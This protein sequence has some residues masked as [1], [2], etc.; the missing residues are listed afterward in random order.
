ML[1][2]RVTISARRSLKRSIWAGADVL[3]RFWCQQTGFLPPSRNL[4]WLISV[5]ECSCT[6]GSVT[7]RLHDVYR[8]VRR[9]LKSFARD[10]YLMRQGNCFHTTFRL[11]RHYLSETTV[12]RLADEKW[13]KRFGFLWTFRAMVLLSMKFKKWSCFKKQW[14]LQGSQEK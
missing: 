2:L 4:N 8:C 12:I 6:T 13:S 14:H 7:A 9:T 3:V 11:Q 5:W 10:Q 1:E